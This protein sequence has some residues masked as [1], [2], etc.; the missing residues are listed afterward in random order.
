MDR[1]QQVFLDLTKDAAAWTDVAEAYSN[2]DRHY[3]NLDHLSNM[4]AQLD[5][6]RELINDWD[7]VLFAL[8]YHDYI[9]NSTGKDNEGQ[10]AGYAKTKMTSLKL[11]QEKID[12]VVDM[13]LATKG[14]DIS[15]NSDINH[16]T[17]A[18]LSILGSTE[19]EYDQYAKN[20]RKEYSIYPDILYKPGRKKVLKHFLDMPAIFKTR[21]FQEKFEKMARENLT[22]ELQRL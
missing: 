9:Y 17:D 4:L 18:D 1:L 20:V 5:L 16:F 22:K 11:P 3:H 19:D 14:H 7:C 10:S 8:F 13:I 2:K 21:F 6:C 12:S 15:E